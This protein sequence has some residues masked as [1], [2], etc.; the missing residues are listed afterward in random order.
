MVHRLVA[1][2]FLPNPENK[3][4]VDHVDRD[5]TNNNVENLQWVSAKENSI[6]AVER[7]SK[8]TILYIFTNEITGEILKFSNRH[9]MLKHFGKVCL[10]YLRQIAD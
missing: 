7:G 2:A 5:R 3:P 1:T 9:K 8:D 10:R 6:L 4:Q